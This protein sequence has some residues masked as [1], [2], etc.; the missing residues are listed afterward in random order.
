MKKT[1][2][3]D[4][5]KFLYSALRSDEQKS[6]VTPDPLLNLARRISRQVEEGD[7][8]EFAIRGEVPALKLTSSEME[9][10]R[11]GCFP[12]GWLT[13]FSTMAKMTKN[14]MDVIS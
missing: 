7:F 1:L 13:L 3:A 6:T 9:Q 2:T 5:A 11:G 14:E 8:I 4:E 10:L 12:F